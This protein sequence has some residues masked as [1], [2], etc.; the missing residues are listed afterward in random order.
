[1]NW[2][3]WTAVVVASSTVYVYV[4]FLA[5][6]TA[7]RMRAAAK[8]RG[9]DLPWDLRLVCYALLIGG[10]P[11]DVVYNWT[12]GAWRFKFQKPWK[13]TYS[14]RV[15]WHV[16]HLEESANPRAAIEWGVLLDAGDPG[17]TKNLPPA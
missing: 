2:V 15:Q 11:A 6:C 8:A 1:V 17:H 7:K 9:F 14:Q 16:D 4:A 3:E 5:L 13:V 12:V 10:A